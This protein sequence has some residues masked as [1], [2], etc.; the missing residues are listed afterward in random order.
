[1]MQRN[2]FVLVMIALILAAFGYSFWI[3]MAH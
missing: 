3:N 2:R 1:M